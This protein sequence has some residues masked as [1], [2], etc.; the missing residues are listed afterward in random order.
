LLGNWTVDLNSFYLILYFN[1]TANSYS[2]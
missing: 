1:L 2:T